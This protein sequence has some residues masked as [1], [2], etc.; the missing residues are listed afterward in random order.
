M[1]NETGKEIEIEKAIQ[2]ILE[3]VINPEIKSHEALQFTQAALNLAH[4]KAV[5]RSQA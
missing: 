2:S 3:K 4:V 1:K 5:T